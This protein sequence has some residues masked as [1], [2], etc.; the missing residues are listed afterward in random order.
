MSVFMVVQEAKIY[1]CFYVRAKD[2]L[3]AKHLVEEQGEII[4]HSNSLVNGEKEVVEV[5]IE[6]GTMPVWLR[7]E[8]WH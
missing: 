6:E 4:P 1:R 7:N 2:A 3:E 5:W 8:S